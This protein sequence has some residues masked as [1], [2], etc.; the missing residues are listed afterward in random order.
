MDHG[1]PRRSRPCARG[2]LAIGVV[3]AALAGCFPEQPRSLVAPLYI[4]HV[5]TSQ[6]ACEQANQIGYQIVKDA[7]YTPTIVTP[8]TAHSPGKI[9]GKRPLGPIDDNVSVTITCK[10]DEVTAHG[11]YSLGGKN[12]YFPHYFYE[13]FLGMTEAVHRTPHLPTGQTRVTMKPLRGADA[14]V[15]FGVEV[16]SLLPVRVEVMNTTT[17][18]YAW[19]TETVV[20]LTP[21]GKPVRPLP[22]TTST[23]PKPVLKSQPLSPGASLKGYLYYPPGSYT[24]ASGALID[25]EDQEQEGFEVQF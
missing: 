11:W 16:T 13:R 23:L 18:T 20:L 4:A 19:D 15:E 1:I 12:Q 22:P 8:A 7:S 6:L 24:S 9:E 25:Q 3:V 14:L 17:R 21:E 10:A 5:P 2:K